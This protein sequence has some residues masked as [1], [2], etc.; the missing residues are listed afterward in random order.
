M[1]CIVCSKKMLF[2]MNDHK[3]FN[4]IVAGFDKKS[5][6]IIMNDKNRIING[7][8]KKIII[9]RKLNISSVP[10]LKIRKHEKTPIQKGWEKGTDN[11]LKTCKDYDVGYICNKQSGIIAVD[12][13]FY[14]KKGKETYDP[15]NN[16]NHKLFIDTFGTDYIKRF[17]T[18]TQKTLNGGFHLIFKHK[19]G[20]RQTQGIQ[21]DL[22]KIDTRGGNTNGYVKQYQCINDTT[23]KHIPDDLLDF[24]KTNIFDK[25]PEPKKRTNKHTKNLNNKLV[26]YQLQYTYKISEKKTIQILNSVPENYFL[27]LGLWFKLTCAMKIIKKK[28]LWD[29]Y[30]KK[31][32]R[33]KYD[34][35]KNFKT[36]DSIDT[37]KY[38]FMFEWLLKS[39]KKS[40][41]IRFYRYLEVPK[42]T[43]ND[44]HH[45]NIDKL[46]KD[47][48]IES[49]KSYCI[50]SDT[51]TG[52]T[53]LFKKFIEETQSEFISITSRRSLAK[54]QYEDFIKICDGQ[55]SYYEY[56]MGNKMGQGI[57]ICI[58][59]ILNLQFHL[60]DFHNK[61]IFLDEFNSIIE[62][63]LQTDTLAKNR[64]A[65]FEYLIND[66]LLECKALI[67]V[68]A[69]ISDLSIQFLKEIERIKGIKLNY[70]QNDYIHNKGTL[71][72]EIH[73]HEEFIHQISKEELFLCPCD[74]KKQAKSLWIQLNEIDKKFYP[75]RD[76]II[77][78]IAEDRQE[79]KEH[80][81][82]NEHK[83]IIFSPKIVYGLDSNGYGDQ[84]LER[85]VYSYYEM[86]TI[87]PSAML[88]QIN[89]E[90]KISYHCYLIFNKKVSHDTI[91]SEDDFK[92][93]VC[94]QNLL[95]L[96]VFNS[97]EK[98]I[99]QLFCS[100]LYYHE[101]KQNCYKSN[102]S[103]HFKMLLN[104][105]GFKLTNDESFCGDRSN[106]LKALKKTNS[107][108]YD[109]TNYDLPYLLK[110]EVNEK[111]LHIYN[112]QAIRTVPTLIHD[113]FAITQHLNI[114]HLILLKKDSHIK[115]LQH[116]LT[117][118]NDFSIKKLQSSLNQ[119][120]FVKKVMNLFNMDIDF[121]I[122][123]DKP[124]QFNSDEIIKEYKLLF[125]DR[126]TKPIQINTE[127]DRV[128][129]VAS[130]LY[131]QL[132][133]PMKN[134]AKKINGVKV[135]SYNL[136]ENE[137]MKHREVHKFSIH[138]HK[139]LNE[140]EGSTTIKSITAKILDEKVFFNHIR[141][142]DEFMNKYHYT[143]LI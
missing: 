126:T 30:S 70:I 138:H 62:Y 54:E 85:P 55:M 47:L 76:P 90:R 52:K 111:V 22:F 9:D 103:L 25:L 31:F 127:Y 98:H 64:D 45:I 57:T 1:N 50:K 3:C 40:K 93:Y 128:K 115:K 12:L 121:R 20:F 67:C 68:D 82:L 122:S 27:D 135:M 42:N 26:K 32:G 81:R 88:Q 94:E 140:N 132:N 120:L 105:R 142:N 79:Q 2:P 8:N 48:M 100:L 59:S 86:N 10:K 37:K 36:W 5:C 34:K 129:F 78:I 97:Q 29:K 17:N 60:W 23:I 51:G 28:S 95:A 72:T 84:Q 91:I 46:S 130:K 44:F 14:S 21:N 101:Y 99:N 18:Y 113:S 125:R 73:E 117:L 131:S 134:K 75:H 13:D 96:K 41:D 69:D 43:F 104:E 123:C 89:R 114:K 119:I 74:S 33:S 19:E 143:H 16:P 24:I 58:D 7:E 133:I 6:D 49:N 53:T 108:I 112:T 77:L 39:I 116:K 61:I 87:S 136:D 110:S 11:E 35:D 80:I 124:N 83:R 107:N 38:E 63:L 56:D 71:S 66:V 102:P 65:I 141:L 106:D 109:I 139:K 137:I 92:A 4:C 15:I 118:N